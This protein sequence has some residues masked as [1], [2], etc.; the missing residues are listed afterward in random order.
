VEAAQ[1]D[2]PGGIVGLLDFVEDHR[3]AV[4]FEL[5]KLGLRWDD[6]GTARLRWSL[7]LAIVQQS[8]LDSAIARDV[9]GALAIQWAPI[10]PQLIAALIDTTSVTNFYLRQLGGDE[11]AT[12]PEPFPRPGVEPKVP[13]WSGT[14]R[15]MEEMDQL[16]GW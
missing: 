15:T 7:L 1:R 6:I 10:L 8:G 14:P 12:P 9:H 13:E 11:R 16:L 5:I 4:E 2:H 3:Q